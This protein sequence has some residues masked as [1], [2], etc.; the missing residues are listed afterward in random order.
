MTQWAHKL[1]WK[2]I[3]CSIVERIKSYISFSLQTSNWSSLFLSNVTM[4]TRS[5]LYFSILFPN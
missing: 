4:I 1:G 3:L 5:H 2:C